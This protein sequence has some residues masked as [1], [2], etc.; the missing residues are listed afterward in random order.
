MK[1]EKSDGITW[2]ILDKFYNVD[3]APTTSPVHRL[4]GKR[5]I[6]I[7]K[8]VNRYLFME[9]LTLLSLDA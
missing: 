5:V 1:M 6:S 2:K 8:D 9:L 4:R 7:G 3:K